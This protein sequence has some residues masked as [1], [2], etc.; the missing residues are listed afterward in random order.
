MLCGSYS[1]ISDI[2][3]YSAACLLPFAVSLWLKMRSTYFA[4]YND[5]V[6]TS[7]IVANIFVGICLRFYLVEHQ[8]SFL[9]PTVIVNALMA[10]LFYS[11][12]VRF[13]YTMF[14]TA[15]ISFLWIVI[16]VPFIFLEPARLRFSGRSLLIGGLCTVFIACLSSITAYE[17]EYFYRMQFLMSKDMKKNQAKLTKQLK[18]LSKSYNKQAGSLDSPLE[19]SVMVIRSVMADPVLSSQHLMALGQVLALLSSSNLLTPDLEGTLGESL[20]NQQQAWLF[21]EIAARKRGGGPTKPKLLRR[22]LSNALVQAGDSIVI[23]MESVSEPPVEREELP[24]EKQ[25]PGSAYPPIL[26]SVNRLLPR[27]VEFNWPIFEFTAATNNH[28]LKILSHQLFADANLF[29]GFSIPEDK[30]VNFLFAIE[31][32]YKKNLPCILKITQI[33]TRYTRPMF[34][35]VFLGLAT[36][37]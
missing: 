36:W 28:S 2:L 10:G 15:T 21:S 30:F 6:S 8:S 27:Y 5:A 1:I 13:I 9:Q 24:A 29:D 18:L 4:R 25:D 22:K 7:V 17:T 20:D 3:F 37:T 32:G 34:C 35:I 16:N 33:I 11:F 23:K 14:T 31:K 26:D 19:R 12:R